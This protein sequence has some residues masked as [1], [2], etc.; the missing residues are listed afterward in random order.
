MENSEK[1]VP[2]NP[3]DLVPKSKWPRVIRMKTWEIN[4]QG[5][6]RFIDQINQRYRYVKT[7]DVGGEKYFAAILGTTGGNIVVKK[8]PVKE[9]VEKY[10]SNVQKS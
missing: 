9:L 10:H 1:W 8:W 5:R 4:P 7:V 6:I 2:F 3:L